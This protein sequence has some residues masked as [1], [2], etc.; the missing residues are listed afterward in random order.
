M[1]NIHN[2]CYIVGVSC[3]VGVRMYVY[4]H[5]CDTLCLLTLGYR[6]GVY[7]AASVHMRIV[8]YGPPTDILVA[9]RKRCV[10]TAILWCLPKHG[11]LDNTVKVCDKMTWKRKGRR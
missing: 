2:E 8:L 10:S 3:A 6:M 1:F 7:S 5:V 4:N 11:F 9:Q